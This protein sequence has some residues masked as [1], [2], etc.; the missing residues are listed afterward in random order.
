MALAVFAGFIFSTSI[1]AKVSD[2]LGMGLGMAMVNYNQDPTPLEGENATEPASGSFSAIASNLYWKFAHFEKYSVYL[3]AS[4]PLISSGG[5]TFFSAGAGIEYYLSRENHRI[6]ERVENFSL[7]I[8]PKIR[9]YVLAE[10]NAIYFTYLTETTK[11]N[12]INVE[13]AGGGGI[14]YSFGG[15]WDKW[16]IRGSGTLSRGVG[17]VTSTMGVRVFGSAIYYLD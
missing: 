8:D 16:A 10:V 1:K 5:H 7:S 15:S 12:D 17:S 4:F 13:I 11:N 2:E 3:G 9:Y 14:T 6:K